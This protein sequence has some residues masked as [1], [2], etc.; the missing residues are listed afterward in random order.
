[1]DVSDETLQEVLQPLV[2]ALRVDDNGVWG[3]VV[4]SQVLHRRDDNLGGIHCG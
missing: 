3:D 4:G 1:M 2:G